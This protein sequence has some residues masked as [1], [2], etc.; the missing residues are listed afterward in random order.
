MD[1]ETRQRS[2][3]RIVDEANRPRK[4]K[5]VIAECGHAWRFIAGMSRICLALKSDLAS[6]RRAP[7]LSFSTAPVESADQLTQSTTIPEERDVSRLCKTQPEAFDLP[8]R[9]MG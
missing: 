9:V 5:F 4:G 1:K 7:A 3:Y 6:V 2:C 8:Y